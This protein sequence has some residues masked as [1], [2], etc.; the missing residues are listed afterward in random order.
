MREIKFR[1]WDKEKSQMCLPPKT[2]IEIADMYDVG[3]AK[4][5][6][7]NV[8]LMQFTGLKDSKGKE[9]YEGDIIRC[10]ILADFDKG[11]DFIG[12]VEWSVES[13]A[14]SVKD[15]KDTKMYPRYWIKSLDD[16]INGVEVI[17]NR[18][19]NPK[20]LKKKE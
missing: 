6:L 18:F 2:I 14:W 8:I 4:I 13:A 16:W 12:V 20:L 1:A 17:G 5:W 9:I 19:E 3:K 7:K 11:Y 10:W 15:V